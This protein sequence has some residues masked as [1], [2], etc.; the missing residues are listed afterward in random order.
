MFAALQ[1]CVETG[2]AFL[3]ETI[4]GWAQRVP[5]DER[6][7]MK[8]YDQC[9]LGHLYGYYPDGC[10]RLSISEDQQGLLGVVLSPCHADKLPVDGSWEVLNEM[11]RKEILAR[12]Q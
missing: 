7:D 10:D 8:Y 9:V 1:E 5:H 11:W 6:L 12:L 4:P 3:D 2:A